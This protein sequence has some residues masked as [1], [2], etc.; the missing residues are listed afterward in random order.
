[1]QILNYL[2]QNLREESEWPDW[3]PGLFD[4]VVGVVGR[5]LACRIVSIKS[6]GI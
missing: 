5:E 4:R 3:E 2:F 6:S 1:M